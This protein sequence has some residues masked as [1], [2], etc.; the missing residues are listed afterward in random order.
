M[1]YSE[2]LVCGSIIDLFFMGS[3]KFFCIDLFD[4]EVDFICF[5]DIEI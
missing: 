2:F 5:F 4:D 1:S 3:D